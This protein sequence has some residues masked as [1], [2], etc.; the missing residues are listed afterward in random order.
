[1][2]NRLT[3]RAR[4]GLTYLANVKDHEQAI[5]GSK[6]TLLCIWDAFDKLA[7]YEDTELSPEEVAAL[8]SE[9]ARLKLQLGKV[10]EAFVLEDVEIPCP[11]NVG[12]NDSYECGT[13]TECKQ[14]WCDALEAVGESEVRP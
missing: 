6:S 9:N 11:S 8:K 7:R 2:N 4:N 10:M 13:G 3:A 14:C 1:M 12:L 5:E